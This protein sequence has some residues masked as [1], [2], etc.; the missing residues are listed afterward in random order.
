MIHTK[1]FI[2]KHFFLDKKTFS[3]VLSQ[4]NFCRKRIDQVT[5]QLRK[6]E[7]LEER[8][9]SHANYSLYKSCLTTLYFALDKCFT[10]LTVYLKNG[11]VITPK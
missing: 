4:V 9:L 7:D 3:L 10:L 8:E 11:T 6:L 5:Q 1:L 2:P